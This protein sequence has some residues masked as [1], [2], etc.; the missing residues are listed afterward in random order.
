M[1]AD[2]ATYTEPQIVGPA[3]ADAGPA[4]RDGRTFGHLIMT[5]PAQYVRYRTLDANGAPTVLPGLAF[6]Y[7]DASHGP[8]GDDVHPEAFGGALTK[9]PIITRDRWGAAQAYGGWDGGTDGWEAD[10]RTVKHIII[11]HS[12]TPQFRD[13]LVEIRSIHYYHAITRG[14]GDIGYNYLVDFL[15]NV[16]EG[17]KGGENVVG[18]HAFQYAYGSAGICSM[19]NFTL[20]SSTPESIAALV[21]ITAWAGRELDP[22]G[23]SDFHETPNCPTIAGHRDVYDSTCPGDGLYADLPYIRTAVAE[24]LAGSRNAGIPSGYDPG[25]VIQTTVSGANLRSK[26]ST[27]GSIEA[28]LERGKVLTIIEGPTTNDGYTWYRVS[29]EQ[30]AGWLATTT[31]SRSDA[32]PPQRDYEPNT[33][34][35]I[36]AN[37]LNLRSEPDLWASVVARLP[38]GD[39][40]TVVDG[41]ALSG[42]LT[43]LKLDTNLG[44][45]W[46]AQQFLA[47]SGRAWISS[48]FAV[49]DTVW[50][51]TN[52]L[53]IRTDTSLQSRIIAR[54][55]EGE[56]GAV[57]GGPRRSAGIIWVQI[58]TD[59]GSGWV[60]EEFLEEGSA[61]PPQ[62]VNGKFSVG[63]EVEV[64]TDKLNV[65]GGPGL[66][67]R[68]VTVLWTGDEATITDGAVEADGYLWYEIDAGH[69]SGWVAETFLATAG[70]ADPRASGFE[71]GTKVTVIEDSVFFR[72]SADTTGRIFWKLYR[73][74]TGTVAGGTVQSDG[75]SWVLCDFSGTL[76]WVA[77]PFLGRGTGARS[78]STGLGV[79]ITVN[80]TENKVNVRPEPGIT[81][82]VL[83]QLYEGAT[84]TIQEGPVE[85]DGYTW[86]RITGARWEGWVT[87]GYITTAVGGSI[88][89]SSSVRVFDGELNMRSGPSTAD[90]V[91]RVLPDGAIVEVLD[92]PERSDGHEWYRVSSSRYGTG[93]VIAAWLERV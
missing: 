73:G 27:S 70:S 91:V 6:T 8:T 17:R 60:S 14:W 43:W 58:R 61:P 9:T 44:T 68:V 32:A 65:R 77:T 7:I 2:G 31:F 62:P 63:D 33:R 29:G 74:D 4:D 19:G 28:R 92:G 5:D 42:G 66:D 46:V 76:G 10:Y 71:V 3:D 15:G 21:W 83:G 16:Y 49:G 80:V 38:Q 26:P 39:T 82:I 30:S 52:P 67:D 41:P 89:L 57:I 48:K 23:K 86:Y 1:S 11:H 54:L 72:E 90:D 69:A 88:G 40:A 36:A 22:L 81:D 59:R 87:D 51:T 25:D 93:W 47:P 75:Y 37:L 53:N 24:V 45:G 13:P 35:E 20:E 55:W 64:D 85:A 18:G 56:T 50:V 12:V 79:G 78:S 34:V 84:A